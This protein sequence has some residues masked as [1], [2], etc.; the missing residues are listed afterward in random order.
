MLEKRFAKTNEQLDFRLSGYIL[1]V[2]KE[3]MSKIKLFGISKET[4]D[5]VRK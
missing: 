2:C 5:E 1:N 4:I 3:E